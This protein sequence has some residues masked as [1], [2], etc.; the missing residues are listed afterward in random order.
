MARKDITLGRK[1][2]YTTTGR[3]LNCGDWLNAG[4]WQPRTRE[5]RWPHHDTPQVSTWVGRWEMPGWGE[6]GFGWVFVEL[7]YN[8]ENIAAKAGQP[9]NVKRMVVSSQKSAF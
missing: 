5:R 7:P 8:K 6:V 2:G 3:L 4:T 9:V 1:P